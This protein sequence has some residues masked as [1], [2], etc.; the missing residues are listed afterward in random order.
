MKILFFLILILLSS[1]A[2][3]LNEPKNLISEKEMSALVAEFALADQMTFAA[4]NANIEIETRFILKQHKIKAKDF[5]ESYT[6][7][8]GINKL[9][10]IFNDAQDIIFEKD[11]KAKDYIKQKLKEKP[12]LPAMGR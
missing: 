7:Y 12:L 8:T 11:P 2:Q 4:P 1:C 6:Y 10:K 3:A 5:Q 9:D